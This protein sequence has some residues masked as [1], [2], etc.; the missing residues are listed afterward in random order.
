M[1]SLKLIFAFLLAPAM[2]ALISVIPAVF[3]GVPPAGIG[4]MLLLVGAVTYAHAIGLGLPTALLIHRFASL[5]LLR[6]VVAAFFIGVAPFGSLL[7]YQELTIPPGAG[8]S[9]NGVILRE[10][11]RLTSDGVRQNVLGVLQLGGLGGIGGLSWW[12]IARPRS[13]LP[14]GDASHFLAID[15]TRFRTRDG[16]LWEK[17]TNVS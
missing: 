6:V 15:K 4:S 1:N 2:P 10:N 5:T 3:A 14:T 16:R 7:L 12:L 13:K 9:E 11:G 8:Y 17:Y